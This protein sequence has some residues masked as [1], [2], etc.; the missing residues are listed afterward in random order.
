M[1][2][3]LELAPEVERLIEDEAARAH[4]SVADV[5]ATWLSEAARARQ[6]QQAVALDANGQTSSTPASNPPDDAGHNLT[7]R[8]QAARRGYGMLAGR[9]GTVDD[10]LAERRAE[11]EREMG[12]MAQHGKTISASISPNPTTS[13]ACRDSWMRRNA[14]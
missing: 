10:F 5:A 7:P 8:Q 4:R 6:A 13:N 3:I 9:G 2:L 12:P 11:A 1:T 14:L